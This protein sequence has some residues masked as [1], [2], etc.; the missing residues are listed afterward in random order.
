MTSS[1]AVAA[2]TCA[3]EQMPL[4]VRALSRSVRAVKEFGEVP[5]QNVRW[6]VLAVP[7]HRRIE[8][9]AG[10]EARSVMHSVCKDWRPQRRS[11]I[12]HVTPL[13]DQ[14]PESKFAPESV[15]SLCL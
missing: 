12:Q 11:D 7:I 3:A 14:G 4:E 9:L 10:R 13:L 6:A 15:G 5:G 2:M 1:N 8:R